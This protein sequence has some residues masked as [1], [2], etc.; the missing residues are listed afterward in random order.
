MAHDLGT[1]GLGEQSLPGMFFFS[2]S[3]ARVWVFLFSLRFFYR[4]DGCAM[5]FLAIPCALQP[6]YSHF[7]GVQLLFIFLGTDRLGGH[8]KFTLLLAGILYH[9]QESRLELIVAFVLRWEKGHFK[10][11]SLI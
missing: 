3:S 1:L 2:S 5:L 7:H 8:L 6:S 9:D 11:G 4:R 10:A